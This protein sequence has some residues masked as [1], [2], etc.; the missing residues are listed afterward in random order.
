LALLSI[1]ALIV[2]AS[3]GLAFT[4]LGQGAG[5]QSAAAAQQGTWT[6][7]NA[8]V[9]G[10][11]VARD[12]VLNAM[13]ASA[14]NIESSTL[15][16]VAAAGEGEFHNQILAAKDSSGTTCVAQ[17]GGTFLCL[18]SRYDPYAVVVFPR[19]GGSAL[20]VVDKASLLG[21]ARSDVARLTLSRQDGTNI[22]L[23]LD[24]WRSFT[25]AATTTGT[26]PTELRVYDA[27]GNELQT[28]DLSASPLS[29]SPT[30]LP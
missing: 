19:V 29:S 17:R 20:N 28:V 3:V 12:A 13:V 26:I 16:E 15:R 27:A 18:D 2:A 14:P 30:K 23:A 5:K 9:P 25:Y 22:D 4:T 10:S 7:P 8:A 1:A 11:A 21:I 24:Q 6:W